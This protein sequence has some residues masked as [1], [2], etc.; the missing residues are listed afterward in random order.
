[1]LRL[2][3]TTKQLNDKQKRPLNQMI[4]NLDIRERKNISAAM[5]IKRAMKKAKPRRV[6]RAMKMTCGPQK[7]KTIT[8]MRTTRTV[9]RT[10]TTPIAW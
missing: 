9:P 4:K 1:M 6:P 5:M 3:L 7:M 2:H 8:I 10:N